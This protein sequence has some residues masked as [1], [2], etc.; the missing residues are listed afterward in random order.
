MTQDYSI[1]YPVEGGPSKWK[2]LLALFDRDQDVR[3]VWFTFGT[4]PLELALNETVAWSMAFRDPP[5]GFDSEVSVIGVSTYVTRGDS[6]HIKAYV[7]VPKCL[8]IGC[9]N[10]VDQKG[11]VTML[12]EIYFR[13]DDRKGSV[14]FKAITG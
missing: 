9:A 6:Y 8:I 10:D 12:A 5:K 11:F 7:K 13:T 2:L 14:I 4:T 3:T 1:A